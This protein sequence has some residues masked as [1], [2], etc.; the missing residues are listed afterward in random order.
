MAVGAWAGANEARVGGERVEAVARVVAAPVGAGLAVGW[1]AT[2][3]CLVEEVPPA[4]QVEKEEEALAV[5]AM[6]AAAAARRGAGRTVVMVAV[7]LVDLDL[8]LDLVEGPGGAMMVGG[9]TEAG[10][11]CNTN[12]PL[13]SRASRSCPQWLMCSRRAYICTG[14]HRASGRA[15]GPLERRR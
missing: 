3:E 7:E 1:V 2:V 14:P 10:S 13:C 8:D 9:W 11:K 12:H 5:V 15:P 4:G 6:G